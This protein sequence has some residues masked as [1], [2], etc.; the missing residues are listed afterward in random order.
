VLGEQ[1]GPN[2]FRFTDE[3]K[4]RLARKANRINFGKLKEIA[5]VVTPQALINRRLRE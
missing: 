5:T 3:Q 2:R 1:H 4:I